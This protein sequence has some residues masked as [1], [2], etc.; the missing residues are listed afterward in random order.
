MYN[1]QRLTVTGLLPESATALTAQAL[2][3]NK[4]GLT[5]LAAVRQVCE[6]IA[7]AP[8][9]DKA[10]GL[11]T[12]ESGQFRA[13]WRDHIAQVDVG[14]SDAQ[15]LVQIMDDCCDALDKNGPSGL[16][17]YLASQ[18]DELEKQRSADN[19]GTQL[20]SPF[21]FWKIVAAAIWLGISVYTVWWRITHGAAWWDIGAV[22]LI[23]TI[24]LIC[25]SLGC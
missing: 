6:E 14:E 18:L 9:D 25:I 21:P 3:F 24:G 5:A 16:S 12:A 23:A 7:A 1:A 4:R 19:R 2:D 8:R 11:W 20:A 13:D 17:V 22:I 15:H 10:A